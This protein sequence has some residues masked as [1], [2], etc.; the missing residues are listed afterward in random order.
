VNKQGD[1]RI[2]A[3]PNLPQMPLD[4]D[5]NLGGGNNNNNANNTDSLE[6][7]NSCTDTFD[8]L[9]EIPDSA[10]PC[11]TQYVLATMLTMLHN[12]L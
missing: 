5:G 7:G 4:G 3:N 12:N 9:N 6:V 2:L 11:A 1:D 8:K 10:G